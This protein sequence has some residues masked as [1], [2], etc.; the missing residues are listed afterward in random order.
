MLKWVASCFW[1]FCLLVSGEPLK[2]RIMAANL[3]SDRYQSYSPDNGN[4]SNPEGAGA[5]ILKALKPDVVLVQEFKTT[6]P[7]RQ[8]VNGCLGPEYHFMCEPE[9]GLPNGIISRF[10]IV[11]SGSWDDPFLDNRD[12]AWAELKLPGGESLW[13]VSVHFHSKK[14]TTRGNEA[15]AL[16]GFMKQRIP[17]GAMRVVG[18]DFNTRALGEESLRR[19]SKQVVLPERMP[20]DGD[21]NPFTN[22]P[23]NRP[24]DRVLTGRVLDGLEVPVVVGGKS[25]KDGLVF[26]SRVFEPLEKVQ[27]VQKGD[28]GVKFMQHMAVVRDFLIE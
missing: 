18:G 26:D 10:P 15:A 1:V 9:V 12:F 8:W 5:R 6:V 7:L 20:V 14:A 17:A 11:A 25:F 3:T 23:R 4:H 2:V 19:F 22:G 28:S 21:G 13:V 27:P 16:A 24:Y